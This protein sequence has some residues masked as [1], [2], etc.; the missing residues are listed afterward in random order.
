MS[1]ANKR[2]FGESCHF[3][4]SMTNATN[5]NPIDKN[6]V[7]TVIDA[8]TPTNIEMVFGTPGLVKA[9]CITSPIV[10]KVLKSSLDTN[11]KISSIQPM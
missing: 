1:V 3:R 5:A 9:K 10:L 6:A 11:E 2:F 7:K 8:N 4:A